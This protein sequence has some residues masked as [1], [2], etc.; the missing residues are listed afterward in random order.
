MVMRM[1]FNP[2]NRSSASLFKQ[3]RIYEA[4]I[5]QIFNATLR[6][7]TSSWYIHIYKITCK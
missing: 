4:F 5:S 7:N 3:R 6:N 1:Q 2:L